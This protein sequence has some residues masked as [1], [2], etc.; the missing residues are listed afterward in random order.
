MISRLKREERSPTLRMSNIGK[1]DRQLWYS[2]NLPEKAEDLRPNTYLK[3]L[4][5][6]LIE[7]LLLFLAE[8]AG[9][10]VEGRQDEH[11][12]AGVKGHRDGVID[13]VLVDAKSAS[14]YS[15]LKFKNHLLDIPGNDGFGYIPQLQSYLS[16]SKDDPIVQD[17]TRAAFLAMDKVHGDL[18][19]DVHEKDDKDWEAEYNRKKEMVLGP[20]PERCYEP[21]PHQQSGNL[22]LPTLCGYCSWKKECHPGLRT[23]LYSNKPVF[24]TKVVREPNVL[25][26]TDKEIELIE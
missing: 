4:Y 14:P 5:G 21:I 10:R 13:G 23:F 2:I 8:L 26:M 7:E 11:S 22:A 15:F 20:I 25:E 17:K 1:P 12:I 6:D 19:L 16:S 24:L 18:A 3:F 9:H